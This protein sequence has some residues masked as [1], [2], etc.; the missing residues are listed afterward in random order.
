MTDEDTDSDPNVS[1]DVF[2]DMEEMSE[3][4]L[5]EFSDFHERKVWIVFINRKYVL[6]KEKRFFQTF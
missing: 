3:D 6:K 1:S 2:F 4:K 5:I